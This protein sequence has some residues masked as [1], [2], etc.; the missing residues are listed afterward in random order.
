M[1]D[2][3]D[4]EEELTRLFIVFFLSILFF[5]WILTADAPLPLTITVSEEIEGEEGTEFD[6]DSPS[7]FVVFV[8]C[9]FKDCLF[10]GR[11]T[12][13]LPLPPLSCKLLLGVGKE[14]GKE[15][16]SLLMGSIFSLFTILDLLFFG[17]LGITLCVLVLEFAGL[18]LEGETFTRLL[19]RA[20]LLR[21]DEDD[22]GCTLLVV[23]FSCG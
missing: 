2:D 18:G 3:D 17:G 19:E 1:D 13:M 22:D 8:V 12:N 20:L 10:I 14:V 7:F 15:A 11:S 16:G 9:C 5:R 6:G 21:D 4:D 23:L